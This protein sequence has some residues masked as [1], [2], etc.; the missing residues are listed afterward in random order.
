MPVARHGQIELYY[1]SIGSAD[2]PTLMMINGLGSQCITFDEAWC[3]RFVDRGL[4]VLRFDNRDVGLSTHLA[5]AP[6]GPMGE[7]YLLS[8]MASDAVAVLDAAGVE[9][10]MSSGGHSAGSSP[11]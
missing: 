9:A 2:D 1:E 7:C 5:D 3:Q 10:A 4:R 11:N 8:D 6:T